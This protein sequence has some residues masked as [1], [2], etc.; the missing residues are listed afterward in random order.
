M[1]QEFP[2]G[3]ALVL[4]TVVHAFENKWDPLTARL[5]EHHPE[6]RKAIHDAAAHQR[7]EGH[8]Q[9]N[10]KGDDPGRIDVRV[11]V[12]HRG[13]GPADVDAEGEILFE[14]RFVKRQKPRV[15]EHVIA[16]GAENHYR[17]GAKFLNLMHFT[18]GSRDIV[19]ID[20]G[21]PL[22]PLMARQPVT[23]PAIVGG[24]Q[25]AAQCDI[26]GQRVRKKERCVYNLN[27]NVLLVHRLHARIEIRQF[28][29]A[30]AV[31]F[32]GAVRGHLAVIVRR[33]A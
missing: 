17:D 16:G 13:A 1:R 22:Q 7:R 19:E 28:H 18:Y 11:E 24:T 14:Q 32:T 20:Y 33:R 3:R 12:T 23:E 6:I 21:R 27:C 31:G 2:Q 10:V 9:G 29:A 5:E 30:D 8:Q 26:V 4:I 25:R 15:I